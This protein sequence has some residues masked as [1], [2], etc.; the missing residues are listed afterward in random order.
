MFTPQQ[1]R[2]KKTRLLMYSLKIIDAVTWK[3]INLSRHQAQE[4]VS[5]DKKGVNCEAMTMAVSQMDFF[6]LCLILR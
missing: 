3:K 6:F 5:R 2:E 4:R 1:K